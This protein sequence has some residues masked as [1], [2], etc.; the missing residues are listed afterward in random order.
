M[1]CSLIKKFFI[2]SFCLIVVFSIFVLPCS[3]LSINNTY[4]D[5]PYNN[6]ICNNL[7]TY[8]MNYDSFLNSDFVVFRSSQYD[9]YIVWGNLR[10]S[11]SSV[12]SDSLVE[13][14]HYFRDGDIYNS[15]YKYQYGTDSDFL[16][17]SDSVNTSNIDGYGFKS[18]IF[19]TFEYENNVLNFFIFILGFLFI[20]VLVRLR[21]S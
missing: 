1:E 12:I 14:I 6:S 3:A 11:G 9:Y 8:A 15:E 21:R 2:F 13:Y 19:S 16:L 5:L 10:T 20:L 17:N 4:S 18:P 7:I